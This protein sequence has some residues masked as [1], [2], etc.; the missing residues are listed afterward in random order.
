MLSLSNVSGQKHE[1]IPGDG[2]PI[3][4]EIYAGVPK[5]FKVWVGNKQ[6]PCFVTFDK[7]CLSDLT[8][9]SSLT[10]AAPLA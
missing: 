4:T 8:L 2:K 9:G 3:E 5:Y 1:T 6:G 10:D 7:C